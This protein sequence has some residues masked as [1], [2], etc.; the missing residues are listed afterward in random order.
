MTDK[1]IMPNDAK[2]IF[3]DAAIKTSRAMSIKY[4]TMVYEL[5]SRGEN[6]IV[7]SL[8]EAFFD[9][10]LHTFDDLPFPDIYHY[11]HSRGII[12]LRQK[13]S[14]YYRVQYNV[15]VDPEKEMIITAGSKAAIYMSLLALIN[16]EDEV[17]IHEP[18]WVSYPEQVKLCGGN[19]VMIPYDKNV[20]EFGSY[21]TCRTKVVIINNPNNPTGKIYTS[22]ELAHL[23]DLAMKHNIFILVDE[24][25]SDFHLGNERFVSFG[26]IDKNKDFS[27]ISNSMSKNY[28]MSGWRIGYVISNE[29][30]INEILKINEHLIT[31]PATILELYMAKH[32]DDV[33]EI[34][35]PQIKNV[36]TTRNE[37]LSYMDKIGL[38]YLPGTATF[39]IFV[40]IEGSMYSS[41]EFC[42]YL[43]KE[44]KICVVPG[45]GYGRSCD[46]FIRVSVGTEPLE[47]IFYA[48]DEIKKIIVGG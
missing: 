39:Y 24:V 4:N 12:Q 36:I 45:I 46:K 6:I 15:E 20:F 29:I 26:D 9:I 5:K 11:S 44:K 19:P 38:K 16:P 14:S 3:S 32:F 34:T 41:E 13:I 48:L 17:L 42:D 22:N 23:A 31:C 25:Y 8:G 27:I 35:K 30:V 21:I 2:G 43:L 33:L 7:L 47:R 40:S 10:P 18:A 37:V 1:S 28:G